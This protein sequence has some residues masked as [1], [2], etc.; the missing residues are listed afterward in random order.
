MR[1][2]A[3]TSSAVIERSGIGRFSK[4]LLKNLPFVATDIDFVY[5]YYHFP[6]K[7]LFRHGKMPL[8]LD[9]HR[10]NLKH[11]LFPISRKVMDPIFSHLKLNHSLL[12]GNVDIFFTPEYKYPDIDNEIMIYTIH[13]L[14]SIKFKEFVTEDMH[15]LY[16][17][18]LDRG[19][20]RADHIITVS[21]SS[22]RDIVEVYNYPEEN[23]SVIYEGFEFIDNEYEGMSRD[24]EQNKKVQIDGDY[25]LIVG[26]IEPKKNHI[27]L[28]KAYKIL[29]ERGYDIKLVIA[30][31]SGWKN[32]LIFD[33]IRE[34]QKTGMVHLMLEISDSQLKKLYQ[35]AFLFVFPSFYEG[36]GLPLLEA[37]S[38]GLPVICSNV[39]SMPEV[40][41]DSALYVN[42]YEPEDI[43]EKMMMVIN[44][45]QLRSKLIEKGK[46]NLKRFSWKKSAEELADV[47]RK[48]Y[49]LFH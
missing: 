34:I 21:E 22:K 19:I 27:G 35:N 28:L 45:N 20:K 38:H 46:E 32:E 12:Y 11:I 37:S 17:I 14:I 13:D 43:M 31:R 7:Y 8:V 47:F 40:M 49:G 9:V 42:P 30:G 26:A 2:C 1:V 23:I 3:F 39:S 44:D 18:D 4:M 36:F 33:E 15:R 5:Y 16:Q 10:P 29:L 24:E 25:I 41:N 6:P 48:V